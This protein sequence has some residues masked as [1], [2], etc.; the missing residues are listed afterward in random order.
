MR[1]IPIFRKAKP[2]VRPVSSWYAGIEP[3]D[4]CVDC[5]DLV[6]YHLVHIY[7]GH[8]EIITCHAPGK[9][10]HTCRFFL[11]NKGGD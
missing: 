11:P 9:L 2:I 5:M 10:V 8:R 1:R 7:K 4:V 3:N 6:K